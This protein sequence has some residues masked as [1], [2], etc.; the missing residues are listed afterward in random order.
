MP[1]K[2]TAK[3]TAKKQFIRKLVAKDAA[4]AIALSDAIADLAEPG[5]EE[6]VASAVAAGQLTATDDFFAAVREPDFSSM[7]FYR[8]PRAMSRKSTF[9]VPPPPTGSIST[10]MRR[11]DQLRPSHSNRSSRLM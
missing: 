5:L 4:D 10:I 11:E 9:L 1:T 6:L 8:D 7:F 2:K 3:D